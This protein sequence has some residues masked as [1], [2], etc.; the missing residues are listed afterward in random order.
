MLLCLAACSEPFIVFAGGAL[1][2]E[3][4]AP[5]EDW[6]ELESE[7]T[8]QLEARPED[9]YSVNIWAVGIGR[10]VYIGTGPDGTRWSGYLEEDPR[11][12]LR[13]GETLYPLLARRV[14]DRDERRQV[15]AAYAEKYELDRDENWVK[16]ALV[17]RLDR[18]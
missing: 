5:P 4:E 3:E 16:D 6:S 7:E 10:D 2:G 11:V 8:F 12:R 1:S 17:Y 13:V 18:R 15:A 14:T 9:P